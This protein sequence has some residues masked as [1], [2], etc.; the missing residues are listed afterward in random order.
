MNR[1]E[2]MMKRAEDTGAGDHLIRKTIPGQYKRENRPAG[3]ITTV[4]SRRGVVTGLALLLSAGMCGGARGDII[5]FTYTIVANTCTLTSTGATTDTTIG[6]SSS[7]D[8]NWG[9]L[10]GKQL[11]PGNEVTK[12]FG[13]EMS[14]AGLPYA[15][16]LTITGTNSTIKGDTMYV[17]DS[18]ASAAGFAVMS[19]TSGG[20][21]E[22]RAITNALLN[23]TTSSLV[24]NTQKKL[25]LTAWPTLMPGKKPA[26]LKGVS[27]ITGTVTITVSYN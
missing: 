15:P 18:S 14:C 1:A 21:T 7:F 5:S 22:Y 2:Q 17:S 9:A 19:T 10:T 11:T 12:N 16:K 23:G 26:D 20:S 6:A 25:L 13:V 27:M 8:V 24:E 3:R 4:L